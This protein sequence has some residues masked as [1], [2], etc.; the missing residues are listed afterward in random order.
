V[1]VLLSFF[2]HALDAIGVILA[3]AHFAVIRP[4][5]RHLRAA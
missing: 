1:L 3:I 5:V 4:K 2:T